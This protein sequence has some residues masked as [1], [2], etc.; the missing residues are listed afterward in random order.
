MM[1][2]QKNMGN[3]DMDVRAHIDREVFQITIVTIQEHEK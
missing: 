2:F 3:I 1:E